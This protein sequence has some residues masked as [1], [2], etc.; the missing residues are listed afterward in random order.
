MCDFVVFSFSY[1]YFLQVTFIFKHLLVILLLLQ[2]TPTSV[3]IYPIDGV[4]LN[5]FLNI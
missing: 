3:T 4:H 2:L 5:I 1:C